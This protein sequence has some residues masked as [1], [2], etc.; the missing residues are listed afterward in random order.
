MNISSYMTYLKVHLYGI[1][2]TMLNQTNV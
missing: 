2:W 1:Q